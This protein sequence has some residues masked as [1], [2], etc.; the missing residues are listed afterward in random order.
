MVL[1]F[2]G[3]L[4]RVFFFCV[5]GCEVILCRAALPMMVCVHPAVFGDTP[6]AAVVLQSASSLHCTEVQTVNTDP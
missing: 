1:A 6:I 4:W 2:S 3:H 5:S